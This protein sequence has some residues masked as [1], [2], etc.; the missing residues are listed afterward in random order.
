MFCR[1]T[2]ICCVIFLIPVCYSIIPEVLDWANSRVEGD[3]E[4][5]LYSEQW[6]ESVGFHQVERLAGCHDDNT[7]L[8][9]T[10]VICANDIDSCSHNQSNKNA[11]VC[12]NKCCAMGYSFSQSLLKCVHSERPFDPRH[13]F[14]DESDKRVNVSQFVIRRT[15][16]NCSAGKSTYLWS[17]K[18]QHRS[19]LSVVVDTG[20]LY[21]PQ[22]W[23]R[24]A[25]FI[26]NYCI[27]GF[28]SSDGSYQ[29]PA[30]SFSYVT[31]FR[32]FITVVG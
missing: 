11:L 30:T 10:R 25:Q 29:V 7:T 17:S 19:S 12:L 15:T 18:S 27:D 4:P 6:A 13:I 31:I 3:R 22:I 21:I 5:Y 32:V 2:T 16:W 9:S 14:R 8:D 26:E 1:C 24:D 23:I 20:K 28:L